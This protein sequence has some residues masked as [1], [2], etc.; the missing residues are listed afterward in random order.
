MALTREKAKGRKTN[1]SFAAFP[2][3]LLNTQ[4]YADLSSWGVKLLMDIGAQF[5][6]KNNGDLQ[7]SWTCMRQRGWRSKGT[8]S[9]A[10][11]ELEEAGLILRTRQGGRNHCSLFAITW[12]PIDE[13]KDKRSG[14]SKLEVKST[15]VPPGTWK[16]GE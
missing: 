11:S 3:V 4:K 14:L 10:V 5:N 15:S 7:A 2:H 12:Q 13:C 9:R 1:H 16:D 8:L 6:G